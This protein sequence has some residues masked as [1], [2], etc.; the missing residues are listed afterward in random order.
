MSFQQAYDR[1]LPQHFGTFERPQPETQQTERA[2]HAQSHTSL[3][4]VRF[5]KTATTQ[6]SES[7]TRNDSNL[8]VQRKYD[9]W[10]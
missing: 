9:N 5:E 4:E 7:H 6:Q 2:A 8:P 1:A 10:T 3:K